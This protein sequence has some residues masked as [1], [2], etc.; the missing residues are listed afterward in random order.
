MKLAP[1]LIDIQGIGR[2][3]AAQAVYATSAEKV[4][5]K[6]TPARRRTAGI[7]VLI[8]VEVGG[9]A[10]EQ[11]LLKSGSRPGKLSTPVGNGLLRSVK[12]VRLLS[13]LVAMLFVLLF[14]GLLVGPS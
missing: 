4:F 12:N 7:P 14:T 8:A 6:L 9:G 1:Q 11:N 3:R 10:S 2:M 5:E 13:M